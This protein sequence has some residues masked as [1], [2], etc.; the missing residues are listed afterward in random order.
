MAKPYTGAKLP[1]SGVVLRREGDELNV[2]VVAVL[3]LG[4]LK[5]ERLKGR[6]FYRTLRP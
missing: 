1:Q 5:T 4:Q 2:Y 6:E 3:N